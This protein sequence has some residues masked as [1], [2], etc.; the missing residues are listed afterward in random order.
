MYTAT[1][2]ASESIMTDTIMEPQ[3]GAEARRPKE[4]TISEMIHNNREA[5][6]PY[7]PGNLRACLVQREMAR[8]GFTEEQA[9]AEIL[10]FS[11]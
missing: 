9:L 1:T 8:H 3:S 7:I 10:A 5:G 6:S 4:L 11:R 2:N